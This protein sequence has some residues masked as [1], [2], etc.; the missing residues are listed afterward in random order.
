[1]MEW[2]Q[3]SGRLAARSSA[4][5]TSISERLRCGGGVVIGL[6][7]SGPVVATR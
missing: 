2:R 3:A 6:K 4:M 1:M 5:A 7:V